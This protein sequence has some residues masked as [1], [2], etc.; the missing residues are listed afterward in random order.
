MNSSKNTYIAITIA[1]LA[2]LI[3]FS[4]LTWSDSVAVVRGNNAQKGS[5][6]RVGT[7]DCPGKDVDSSE[8]FT[9]DEKKVKA[10]LTAVC[11]DGSRYN[12]KNK[13]G[14]AFCTYKNLAP[15]ECKGG[16]NTGVMYEGVESE[17][18]WR[19]VGI[20][21]CPGKDVGRSEGST[22]NDNLAK[23]GYT[24][25]CWDG[26]TYNNKNNPGKAF[27]TYKNIDPSNCKGGRNTGE[28]YRAVGK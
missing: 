3:V 18:I 10:G 8:G 23:K 19:L 1:S 11:W 2:L 4:V 16:Q 12:N 24:A 7:G 20:G 9:P 22:P 14:K 27:C 28:M 13:P 5:W 17:L 26:T 6:K 25:V 21:D 15:G